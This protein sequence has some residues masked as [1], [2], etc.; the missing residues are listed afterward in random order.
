MKES[1]FLQIRVVESDNPIEFQSEFNRIQIELK[2]KRPKSQF[3]IS[4]DKYKAIITFEETEIIAETASDEL[5]NQGLDFTCS[6]CPK[7]EPV[8]NNDGTVKRTSKH[9]SC[10]LRGRTTRTTAVC[11]WFSREYLNGKIQIVEEVE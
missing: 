6:Q 8:R 5:Y 1:R 3:D 7:F 11:E 9:G 2:S 10:F 4:S